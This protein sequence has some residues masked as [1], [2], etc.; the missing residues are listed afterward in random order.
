MLNSITTERKSIG[1]A[2]IFCIENAEKSEEIIKII[3]DSLSIKDTPL[4]KK[5]F[6]KKSFKT[7]NWID[8]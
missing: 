5:V 2:M 8:N 1:E 4:S 3:I 6:K 7:Q